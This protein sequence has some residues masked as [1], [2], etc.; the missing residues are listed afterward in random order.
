M[1]INS[2]ALAEKLQS[3]DATREPTWVRYTLITI[4]LLFFLSCLI[5]PLILVFVEAFKQGVGVYAQALVHPDTLSAV[6][7][8]LLTAVIAV[9]LNVVFGVAAAWCVAKFNFR[10]KSILTT[11]I[12]MPFSVSPVIAGLMLVLIFGTQGWFGSW[13]MDNDIKILY[14]VPAIVLAT[15]FITVPFVARELIPLMEAQGT[16]EE[17]AAIVL[18]ASGWQTFWKVTLPNIK[19]GLIY[20]VILCNARAMGEFGAVSVVSGHI[21]SETNT[22]PLHVEILYNEYTFSA[23]FAVS[24][25]LALLAI[26][27]LVLKTWVEIRQEKQNKHNDSTV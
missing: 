9:P 24:S 4:A 16:E 14:A 8:T 13:L 22:L 12:D 11:I 7:L 10:G 23:A 5:L 20:G 25:L 21:R 3:R 1:N 26:V 17:E 6:K 27:T 19:W 18:G 2:N 15:I